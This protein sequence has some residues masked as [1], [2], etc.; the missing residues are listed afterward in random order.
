MLSILE[1]AKAI[2]VAMDV[3]GAVVTSEQAAT[4]PF[5]Y[6]EWK[7]IDVKGNTIHYYEGDRHRYGENNVVYECRSEHDA[8]L[9]N[10]PDLIPALWK[11]LNVENAGTIEDP[12]PYKTGMEIFNGKYYT[13]NE[14]LYL[15][16]RNSNT[17]LYHNLSALVGQYV[18]IIE[19]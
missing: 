19:S 10:T 3:A 5:L 6:T 12:I 1:Q 9:H 11:V 18:E 4:M 8:E 13:E 17:P 7:A 15:C 14:I 16:N 2:R